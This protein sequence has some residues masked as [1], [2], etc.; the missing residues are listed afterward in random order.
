MFVTVTASRFKTPPVVAAAGAGVAGVK[1]GCYM[2]YKIDNQLYSSCDMLLLLQKDAICS[3]FL[4]QM[5]KPMPLSLATVNC[6]GKRKS[7]KR[8]GLIYE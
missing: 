2:N 4:K 1:K 5:P 3:Y 7:M 6:A 8:I